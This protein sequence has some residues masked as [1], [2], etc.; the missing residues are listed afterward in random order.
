[1]FHIGLWFTVNN[2]HKCIGV[3][4]PQ[5]FTLSDL[6]NRRPAPMSG[7]PKQ[8]ESQRK[9]DFIG[10]I[11]SPQREIQV[12]TSDAGD[13]F[14]DITQDKCPMTFVRAKLL[15][16]KMA[17]GETAVLR[18]SVGDPLEN[19]PRSL[20]DHGYDVTSVTP[21]RASA[22]DGPWLISFRAV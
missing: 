14:L 5:P 20:A 9:P 12:M 17:A 11:L 21:E 15:A 22:P 10:L 13:F 7:T 8:R 3:I 2:P 16:E 19:L 18:V 6:R 1:M 4:M